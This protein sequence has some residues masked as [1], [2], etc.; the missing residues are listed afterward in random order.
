MQFIHFVTTKIM[1][2]LTIFGIMTSLRTIIYSVK[3]GET[4]LSFHI[5]INLHFKITKELYQYDLYW[6]L[7]N[8]AGKRFPLAFR[9]Q[10]TL[11]D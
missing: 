6:C 5:R 1:L 9:Q 4:K 8:T 10:F 2:G 11:G 7:L 3:T